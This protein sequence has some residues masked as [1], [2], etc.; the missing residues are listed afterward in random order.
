MA[1]TPTVTRFGDESVEDNTSRSHL[2]ATFAPD[3]TVLEANDTFLRVLGYSLEE[4]RGKHHS[5]FVPPESVTGREYVEFWERLKRGEFQAAEFKCICKSGK[6]VWLWATY[7]PMADNKVV[8]VATDV[9]HQKLRT[10]ELEAQSTAVRLSQAVVTFAM[11]GTIL[12][13][14]AIFLHMMGYTLDE[15][16]GKHHRL[17]VASKYAGSREYV[18]FWERLRRGE[19]LAVE[20]L[21]IGKSGKEVW[22]QATYTP[23]LD[24]NG[25]PF[26]VVKFASDLTEQRRRYTELNRQKSLFLANMSH[27]IRTPMNGIFGMLS[28]L[29]DTQL[30]SATGQSYV[31][32]CMRSAE[33]L[34]AVLNDI[35]LFSKADAGAIQLERVP[36]NLNS[37]VEDVLHIVSSDVTCSQQV[38]VT[39]FIKPDV[40][41]F[42]LGDGSRLRQVLLNLLSNAVKFYKVR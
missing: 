26:K 4:V 10:A 27:E 22:W 36:F 8:K 29:R 13:A 7:T 16:K 9:T 5:I 42:L 11:D 31:D 14:N 33:S 18:D 15:L 41:L 6:E 2:V 34:L 23:V 30:D 37:V 17:L 3:G 24:L 20:C 35:L 40:P 28:L 39:Y 1:Q 25:R 12:D 21:R 32:T 38:D 19:F